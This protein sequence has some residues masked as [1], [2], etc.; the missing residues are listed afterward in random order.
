MNWFN[1]K[2]K[3]QGDYHE[4]LELDSPAELGYANKN[5]KPM[6][7]GPDEESE[8]QA[9][10]SLPDIEASVNPGRR[11]SFAPD[12]EVDGAGNANV[13]PKKYPEDD[14]DAP[15]MVRPGLRSPLPPP[16]NSTAQS[17]KPTKQ[18]ARPIQDDDEDNE[19]TTIIRRALRIKHDLGHLVVRDGSMSGKIYTFS[20]EQ[21][22]TI[23]SREDCDVQLSWER[24]ISRYH[25]KIRM[26]DGVFFIYDLASTNGT[27]LN[28][29]EITKAELKDGDEVCF[30]ESTLLFKWTHQKQVSK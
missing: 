2:Q 11:Q 21:A 4:S 10:S 15:T 23:G 25:A 3:N 17:S 5:A 19:K 20:G 8:T 28:G 30:G 27:L 26:E 14:D 13:V 16:P 9:L 1:K 12:F 7:Y 18:P 6:H 29:E 22:A 24:G